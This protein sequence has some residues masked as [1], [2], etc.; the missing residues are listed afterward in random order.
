M[1]FVF[2]VATLAI[3]NVAL[4]PLLVALF[5]NNSQVIKTYLSPPYSY[6]LLIPLVAL[7]FVYF[8]NVAIFES[9]AYLVERELSN[10]LEPF[11]IKTDIS[12]L[13]K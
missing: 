13:H 2:I 1:I 4:V 11:A 8:F 10:I 3:Y 6:Y 12:T 7:F 5:S 9:E